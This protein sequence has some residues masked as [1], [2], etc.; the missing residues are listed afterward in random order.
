MTGNGSRP[1][2]RQNNYSPLEAPAVGHWTPELQVSVVIPAHG[3]QYVLDLALAALSAQTYPGHLTE[4]II[5]DDGSEPPVRLPPIRPENTRLI[6]A[7]SSGWGPGHA[8]NA[9][10]KA[11]DGTVIQRFDAD[12]VVFREHLEALMRWHH[13]TD[14]VVA[15]GGKRFIEEP[16]V[17]V[18][19]MRHAV[20]HDALGEIT[21]LSK[22]VLH[23]TEQVVINLD[24]LRR[25][26][27]PYH[28]LTG[29]TV[30]FHRAMFDAVGGFDPA[31]I[32]GED[33]ELGY[34]FA[35]YGAV[36]VAD[37]EAR[38]LHIG[39]S[40][41][42]INPTETV[43]VV[44]PYLAHRIPLRRDLREHGG[45]SWLVPYVDVVFDVSDATEQQVH[46]AVDA[47]LSGT[48]PDVRVTLVAP[49]STLPRGRH[50]TLNEPAFELRMLREAYRHDP[51]VRLVDEVSPTSFPS[52]YRYVGPLDVLLEPASLETMIEQVSEGGPGLLEITFDDGREARL[53]RTEAVGRALLLAAPDEPLA[54]VIRETHG[55][56]QEASAAFWP[57]RELE[58][59][60]STQEDDGQGTDSAQAPVTGEVARPAGRRSGRWPGLGGLRPSSR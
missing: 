27:A 19:D 22:A 58:Q 23:S 44:A 8:V 3:G 2:I 43:R 5:V 11:S 36:F 26:K 21:D 45:R 7:D 47:A 55:V 39:L 28:A 34:R 12:M 41:Q 51:R 10:V 35:Q 57:P 13:L 4:V 46:E 29:P 16:V 15:I 14:Y 20:L 37:L 49:W 42:G 6:V 30:S 31:V 59:D 17:A 48:L 32:R 9:G 53:E 25:S 50:S 1:R 40:T 52:P 60:E 38:G 33:T 54:D 56:R 24:G 18:E